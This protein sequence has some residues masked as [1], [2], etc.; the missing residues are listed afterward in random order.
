MKKDNK[1]TNYIYI[2]EKPT[3]STSKNNRKGDTKLMDENQKDFLR[4]QLED[5]IQRNGV[6]THKA[7]FQ[8]A[9]CG[10]KDGA[11]FVPNTNR[12][13]W[14]CF[15]AKHSGYAKD[16]GD[17]FDYV[18]QLNN[19]DF[20]GACAILKDIYTN[21]CEVTPKV[22][23]ASKEEKKPQKDHIGLYNR[24]LQNQFNAVDYLKSRGLT[25]ADEIAKE[26]QIGYVPEYAY[27]F[28]D[29]K[30]SK[31]TPAVIIP[32]SDHSY[33]WR[34][35][36]ENIKKKSGTI[37]PLNLKCLQNNA[38]KWVFLVEGE[39]DTFSILDITK[40]IPNCEFSAICLSS[41]VNLEKF[42]DVYISK[43][44]QADTGLIIALDNDKSPN[45]SIKQATQKGLS[46]AKKHK[47]PCVVADVKKLYLNQKDSNEAL[48]YNREEFKR[49]LINQ[50][51]EVKNM[52]TDNYMAQCEGAINHTQEQSKPI[53]KLYDWDFF[54]ETERVFDLCVDQY[55]Y[56]NQS[57]AWYIYNGKYLKRD[58]KNSIKKDILTKIKVQTTNELEEYNRL[59]ALNDTKQAKKYKS[60]QRKIISRRN[61]ENALEYTG[62]SDPVA[63]SLPEMDNPNLLNCNDVTIDLTTLKGHQHNINDLCTK[64]APVDCT[65]PLN[66]QAV[67]RWNDFIN[68]IMCNDAEMVEFIQRLFGY[69]LEVSNREECFTILYGNTTRNG[70]STLLESIS[71]AL[72]DYSKTVSSNTLSERPTGKDANPE[73]IDLIGAK[74]ITCG[75]L[76]AETLLNDTLLKA[77]SGNDTVSARLLFS[78]DILNLRITG[79]IFANCNEL[80]PMKN[81]DLLNSKRIIVVPFDRHF[82]EHEQD[83]DLKALFAQPEYK[84]VILTWIIEG[85]KRYKKYGLKAH[86]PKKVQQAI[87]NYQSEANTINQFINDEEVFERVDEKDYSQ[88]VKVTDTALY[89]RYRIWCKDNGTLP[90]S[91]TNFKK[92]LRKHRN[93][94]KDSRY[95]NIKYKDVLKGYKLRS[96]VS[97]E[98]NSSNPDRLVAISKRELDRLKR[99]K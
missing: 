84:S 88:A 4:S 83:K 66:P 94:V 80:P 37:Y 69:T 70:K 12:T 49:T 20:K 34:S 86:M 81:D 8:C 17:I 18:Q 76:N 50:V 95:K 47:I 33:S 82:E 79:K 97:D 7:K 85:Y 29:N 1:I 27:E 11:N 14:K 62:Y 53:A 77:L 24:A 65:K 51:N 52:D 16:S 9:I 92:H 57:K 21:G 63:I 75:E 22:N 74:L 89:D 42:I 26:F 5:Y 38:I 46:M 98:R 3:R 2:E 45:D 43:N 30:P 78:N 13:V 93:Y 72:G 73:I 35:T 64:V 55:R 90:H 32:L 28:K 19:V 6:D 15:S 99:K 59:D 67:K 31:T 71:G 36:T 61:L 68:E 87:D 60:E 91:K 44:I 25:H 56:C 23:R 58:D 96:L 40:D 10:D 39:Y 41:A 48:K 54:G